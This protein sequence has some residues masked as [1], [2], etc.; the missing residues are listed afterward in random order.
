MLH[1]S[2]WMQ[3]MSVKNDPSLYELV[4][5]LPQLGMQFGSVSRTFRS[6]IPF[7]TVNSRDLSQNVYF[8]AV[9]IAVRIKVFTIVLFSEKQQ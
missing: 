6:T 9:P 2:I 7:E 3:L 5:A 4:P 1:V 8:T